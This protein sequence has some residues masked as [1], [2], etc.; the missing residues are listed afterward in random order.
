MAASPG[1]EPTGITILARSILGDLHNRRLA[2]SVVEDRHADHIRFGL[3][4][5]TGKGVALTPLPYH[6]TDLCQVHW[7]HAAPRTAL[8]TALVIYLW[9]RSWTLLPALGSRPPDPR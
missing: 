6:S 2:L 8:G 5:T 9:R 1:L 7:H 3:I 4:A